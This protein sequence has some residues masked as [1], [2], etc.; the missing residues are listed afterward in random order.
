[1]MMHALAKGGKGLRLLTTSDM[2]GA[3]QE[4]NGYR[5]NPNGLFE[6]GQTQYSNARYLRSK[7]IHGV[8]V[9]ILFD[10][11]IALPKSQYK[12]IFMTRNRGEI[13]ASVKR[14]E[15]YHEEGTSYDWKKVSKNWPP[16]AVKY[17]GALEQGL[18][19]LS[20]FSCLRPYNQYDIDHVLGICEARIDID[21]IK[22][23]YN[24]V[25]ENPEREFNRLADWGIPIDPIKSASIVDK[26]FYRIRS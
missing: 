4:V 16:K 9:K 24:D 23:S 22:V 5:P 13:D 20:P 15:Q 11:L 26:S 12:I 7:L 1:M 10:G 8:L 21:L 17:I 25:I 6:V 3:N 19:D 2:E 14:V 18:K